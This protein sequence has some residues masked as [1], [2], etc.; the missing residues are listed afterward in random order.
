LGGRGG[1]V[2][3]DE[4]GDEVIEAGQRRS[5]EERATRELGGGS[6]GVSLGGPD[7]G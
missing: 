5:D 4:D 6:S 3:G 7:L 1:Y 2:R